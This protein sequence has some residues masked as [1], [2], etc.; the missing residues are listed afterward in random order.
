[1][2]ESLGQYKILDRIGAGGMGEVYRARDTRVGRTVAIKVM[3]AELAGDSD[4]RERFL[5][6]ARA[7][8]ALSH[9]NIA[10]LYEIG[11]DQG[12]LFLAFEFVPGE[13]LKNVIA[14]RPLN[15][16]RAVDFAAQIADAL[17]EA[18]A[19][20]IVHRDIKP[21]NVIITP[22]DKAKILD[23]GLATWTTGGAER[24]LAAD[25]ATVM[26]TTVGTALGTVA[27]MSPE[28]ALGK[29]VDHRTDIFSVG[30]V[31]FEMLTGKLPFAGKTATA[32]ALEIV[33]STPAPASTINR[34]VPA[35]LD[36]V[37]SKAL[38][39]GLEQRYESAA[40]MTAE[41]FSVAA[42]LD[43]RTEISESSK[44]PSAGAAPPRRGRPFFKWLV[45]ALLLL[46][47]IAAWLERDAIQRIW[48]RTFGPAP[49]PVI[50]VTPLDL[51]GTDASQMYFAD[52]LTEDLITRL[53]Q[54]PGLKVLGRSATR[55]YRGRSPRD[56][57]QELGASV[58]LTGSV[59][60]SGETVKVSLELIDPSDGTAF[61]SSQYT[62][63]VKD[64]F[65]V[66]AQVANDVA[67]A[68]GVT[69]QPSASS[70][71]TAQRLVDRQAYELYLRGRQAMAERRLPEAVRLYEEAIA[72]DGGLAEAFAGVVEA[73]HYEGMHNNDFDSP[74]RRQRLKA[75]AERAHQLDP[76]LPQ[77]NLAMALAA[78]SASQSLG[79]LRRALELD[80]SYSEA[81]HVIGDE[82]H[83]FDPERAIVFWRRSLALD[84]RMDINDVDIAA[85]LLIL[86]RHEEARRELDAPSSRG[87]VGQAHAAVRLVVDLDDRRYGDVPPL[88]TANPALRSAA[89][90]WFTYVQ[91]LQTIGRA[92][93]ALAEAT[94]FA[95]G[96]PGSCA[97]RA[98][99]GGL[100]LD[101]GMAARGRQFVEPILDG[102]RQESAA[103]DLIRCAVLA[104][105]AADKPVETAALIER[106]AARPDLLRFWALQPGHQ[107]GSVALRGRIYPWTKVVDKPP[108]VAARQRLDTAY[109]REREAAKSVLKGLQ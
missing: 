105:A 1:M 83:D 37:L 88:L 97:A 65:A 69:L 58:V 77:A 19:H 100:Q 89:P 52:G 32:L 11:E 25:T 30:I 24:D 41:L 64:I 67:N 109:A 103:P 101:R 45:V 95:R 48:R 60:P 87:A 84:P 27:Y 108:V 28:Q 53:G 3:T 29:R 20:G 75:A 14:G 47:A 92:N 6:E 38:A 22:K 42:I 70:T 80:S 86:G 33:Q 91:A 15:P 62:R 39:K 34:A 49:A 94:Q 93:D 71:R 10:A 2:F 57:A 79:H 21:D 55:G 56:V 50:A 36:A 66:Q 73:L 104:A 23:F 16:R 9:P 17:A 68:L 43:M 13:T 63:D 40:T 98:V 18:H 54:T 51:A 96:F 85:A 74:S 5:R 76:D 26:A 59:R 8:A 61:W 90:F 81:Y 99:L 106:V 46:T 12:Q 7:S 102:A 4:R 72:A 107:S 78:D 82:I 35:E 44:A 31:L